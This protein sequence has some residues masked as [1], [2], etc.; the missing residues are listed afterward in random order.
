MVVDFYNKAEADKKK[1]A[2][3]E[4]RKKATAD[5]NYRKAQKHWAKKRAKER[6]NRIQEM[7]EAIV[8]AER[9]KRK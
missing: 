3:E 2:E 1:K 6:E 5:K 8:I 4:A 7:A 9:M